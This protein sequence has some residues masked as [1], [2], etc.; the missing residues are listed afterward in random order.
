MDNEE[1]E[2]VTI[3][4]TK[5]QKDWYISN[6]I[7]LSSLVRKLLEDHKNKFNKVMGKKE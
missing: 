6:N 3:T 5:E 4:I 7:N 1:L 2:K